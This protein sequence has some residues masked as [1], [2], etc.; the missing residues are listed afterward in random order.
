MVDFSY[1]VRYEGLGLSQAS[2]VYEELHVLA[3]V[4]GLVQLVNGA[5]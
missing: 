3:S 5:F 4:I 2:R 1:S